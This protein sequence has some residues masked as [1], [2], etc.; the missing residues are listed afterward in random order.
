MPARSKYH[1]GS[2]TTAKR[3]LISSSIPVKLIGDQ[4]VAEI[5][6]TKKTVKNIHRWF[7]RRP[8]AASRA[9]SY[10][11][12]VNLPDDDHKLKLLSDTLRHI[13]DYT[14]VNIGDADQAI[15]DIRETH[16]GKPP[17]VLDPFGG[18]GIIPLECIR[19]GCEVYSNDYNP[20]AAVLQK[21][22][23]EYPQ[24]YNQVT[25]R[26]LKRML[27]IHNYSRM[28]KSGVSGWRNLFERSW[29]RTSQTARDRRRPNI[30]GPEPSRVR[31]PAAAPTYR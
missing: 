6:R 8:L 29:N 1:T 5:K 17:K 26:R 3:R 19:L 18:G 12:L 13:S 9:T 20:V 2:G 11:A 28:S 23:L 16:G 15:R 21:C 30:S 22:T 7:A 27:Q 25:R 10:A 4:S 24:K 31:S 14:H